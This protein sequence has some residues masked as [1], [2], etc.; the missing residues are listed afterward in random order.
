[1][2]KVINSTDGN[3]VGLIKQMPDGRIVQIGMTK[4]HQMMLQMLLGSISQDQP[5]AVLPSEYDL[6][7]KSEVSA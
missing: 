6:V 7:L 5:M 1:M 4:E 2:A 3:H